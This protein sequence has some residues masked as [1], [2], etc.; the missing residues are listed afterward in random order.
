M[1]DLH[2]RLKNLPKC[3]PIEWVTFV[4]LPYRHVKWIHIFLDKI[5]VSLARDAVTLQL[6]NTGPGLRGTPH[7]G[8]IVTINTARLNEIAY[9]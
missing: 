6:E 8:I 2:T 9:P 5:L 3:K 7:Q 4:S 1:F